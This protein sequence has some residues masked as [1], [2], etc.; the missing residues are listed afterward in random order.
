MN[1]YSSYHSYGFLSENAA[2]SE[3]LAQEGIVFIGPPASAI[4][5]MG[6]KR[7]ILG[8]FVSWKV[9]RSYSTA[10]ESKNIM[11]GTHNEQFTLACIFTSVDCMLVMQQRCFKLLES[12][13]FR[14]I[15]EKIKILIISTRKPSELVCFIFFM[16]LS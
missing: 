3:R 5:S 15:M 1:P 9:L 7:Y 2:F 16:L 14:D 12:P 13:V 4:I 10:S 8:L 11:L 6:S